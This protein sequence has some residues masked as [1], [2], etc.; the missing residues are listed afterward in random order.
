[1]KVKNFEGIPNK[2]ENEDIKIKS[3]D[4]IPVLEISKVLQN[5]LGLNSENEESGQGENIV[6][7]KTRSSKKLKGMNTSIYFSFDGQTNNKNNNNIE[8]GPI[9]QEQ[10]LIEE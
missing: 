9:P 2:W 3:I 10:N 4:F 6:M 7:N 1:M 5:L 8:N